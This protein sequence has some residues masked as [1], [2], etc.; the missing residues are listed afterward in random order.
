MVMSALS[1]S[2][3]GKFQARVDS[4]QLGDLPILV[5]LN[6][7]LKRIGRLQELLSD[8]AL[9]PIYGLG[10]VFTL[11]VEA[12]EADSRS[13]EQMLSLACDRRA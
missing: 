13:V 4:P 1:R 12:I 10:E 3:S 11:A 7:E 8:P 6:P 9:G 5:E 2:R